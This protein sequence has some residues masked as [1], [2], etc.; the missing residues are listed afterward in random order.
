[1]AVEI[2]FALGPGFRDFE[3]VDFLG[4]T[5]LEPRSLLGAMES[6]GTLSRVPTLSFFPGDRLFAFSSSE[7][8]MR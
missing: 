3:L 6:E 8:E 4:E 5:G 1:M 2:G 7:T